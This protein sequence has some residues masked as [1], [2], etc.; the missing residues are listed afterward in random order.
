MKTTQICGTVAGSRPYAS[1]MSS[2]W[3]WKSSWCSSSSANDQRAVTIECASNKYHPYAFN[4]TV[5]ARLIDLC[6]DICR[7]NGKTKLLWFGNKEKT[8]HYRPA[9]D[10]MVLTVHRWFANKACPG[11]WL[12][13]R[14]ENLAMKVTQALGGAQEPSGTD[15]TS[16]V[17]KIYRVQV[18]AYT[19]RKNAEKKLRQISAT[20]TDCFI[21]DLQEGYYRVQCGAYTIRGN[22]E[23]KMA[24][25]K[26]MGFDAIIKEYTI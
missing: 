2:R 3:S 21:T 23:R 8:L 18:G 6:I 17:H 11:D 1:R 5:Y 9:K 10:E 7:R 16:G 22:A 24:E 13:A 15:E 19:N 20:G 12:M 4:D 26:S 14:M 25:L